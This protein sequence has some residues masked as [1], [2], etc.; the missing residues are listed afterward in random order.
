MNDELIKRSDVI[1]I[2]EKAEYHVVDNDWNDTFNSFTKEI[3]RGV[4][5]LPLVNAVELPCKVGDTIFVLVHSY[6]K[7]HYVLRE[8]IIDEFV[9]RENNE[10]FIGYAGKFFADCFNNKRP[11]YVS[12]NLIG[13]SVFLDVEEAMELLKNSK[14]VSYKRMID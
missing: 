7:D 13:K 10:V 5:G 8:S 1:N 4:Y 14:N 3:Y 11:A 2:L 12:L 6:P 9:I